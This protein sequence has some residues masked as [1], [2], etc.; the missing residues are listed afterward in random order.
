MMVTISEEKL[1]DTL[2]VVGKWNRKTRADI[3]KLRSLLGCLIHMVQCSHIARLFVNCM[4][5]TV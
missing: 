4:L 1:R 3:H 2:S 5:A